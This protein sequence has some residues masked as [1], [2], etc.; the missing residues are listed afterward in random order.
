MASRWADACGTLT[1]QKG[2]NPK[3]MSRHVLFSREFGLVGLGA[4]MLCLCWSVVQDTNKGGPASRSGCT[5]TCM[6]S[7]SVWL[8]REGRPQDNGTARVPHR[9]L[10]AHIMSATQQ[11]WQETMPSCRKL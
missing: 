10:P 4:H 7:N 3:D 2:F 9:L 11:Q 1:S 5:E 6:W 8:A